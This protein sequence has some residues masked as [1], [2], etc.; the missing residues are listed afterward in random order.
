[1]AMSQEEMDTLINSSNDPTQKLP[2]AQKTAAN[3]TQ[4]HKTKDKIFENISPKLELLFDLQ[5]PVSIELGR[6]NMLIRDILQ[7]GRGSVIEFDKLVSEPID[8]IIN[9]KKIAEGEVV[10]ID[11]H[12]GIRITQLIDQEERLKSLNT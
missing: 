7:L 1:M 10:V 8:V 2:D 9:G 4:E 11:K 12:F 5:L 6:T 3:S